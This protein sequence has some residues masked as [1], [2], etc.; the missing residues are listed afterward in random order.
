MYAPTP[1]KAACPN[2]VC[3]AGSGLASERDSIK[4]Y[5]RATDFLLIGGGVVVTTGVIWLL[6]SGSHS[7]SSG[8]RPDVACF[9]AGCTF[10]L[11]GAF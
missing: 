2:D 6:V 1:T 4:R 9:G 8:A 11:T 10:V 5:G 7:E 3:P